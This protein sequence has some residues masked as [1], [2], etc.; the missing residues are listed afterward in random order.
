M[1]ITLYTSDT[2]WWS[3]KGRITSNKPF[4]THLF[5]KTLT[6][7]FFLFFSL[8][9]ISTRFL[10][11][12][13]FFMCVVRT[14]I[15]FD[16]TQKDRKKDRIIALPEPHYNC[17]RNRFFLLL[18]GIIE[19]VASSSLHHKNSLLLLLLFFFFFFIFPEPH[20]HLES[21]ILNIKKE[22]KKKKNEE[23]SGLIAAHPVAFISVSPA[24]SPRSNP[25]A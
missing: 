9:T 11:L 24:G 8:I 21:P 18:V 25:P 20:Q 22:K 17:G 15:S 2:L 5:W 6:I 13:F 3:S 1:T 19:Q 23:T 16:Q 4:C 12:L 14:F 7:F 10:L